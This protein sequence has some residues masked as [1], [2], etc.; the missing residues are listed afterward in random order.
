MKIMHELAFAEEILNTVEREAQK[1][2]AGQV[3]RICLHIGQYS[4]LDKS[5]LS[6]CL[7]A[8]SSGT[9][10]DGARIEMIDSA[11]HWICSQCGLRLGVEETV[12]ICPACGG[13]IE[14]DPA[15]DLRIQEI[16]L[17]DENTE[18]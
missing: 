12:E 6:F 7:E 18:T 17:D 3:H 15:T 1:Y 13:G 14:Y 10:M 4:G 8:I 16:E 2:H 9:R 11:P 5:S